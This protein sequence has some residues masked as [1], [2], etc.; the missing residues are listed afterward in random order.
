M[1]RESPNAA[2]SPHARRLAAIAIFASALLAVGFY[3]HAAGVGYPLDDS[4]IHIAFARHLAAGEGFG[5]NPGE[6][7][8]GATSP[9]WIVL[10][11]S[12]FLLGLPP[13]IW[14]WLLD[15][16]VL[17][18]AGLLCAR[19]VE[20]LSPTG[21]PA[22]IGTFPFAVACGVA[23]ASTGPLV[24]SAAGA[25]E[26]PLLA[27]LAAATFLA[28]AGRPPDGGWKTGLR[29]GVLAGLAG[30][31]RP[32]GL[33]ITPILALTALTR[34]GRKGARE[35]IAGIAAS[36]LVYSPSILFCLFT[37]GR[38]FP[39]TFYAKTTA[40][41]AGA[42][43]IGFLAG[44]ARFL[45]A[46][47]P[48]A[49]VALAVG[50][51]ALA[52]ALVRL[53]S[54]RSTRTALAIGA[55]TIGLPLAYASMGRTFLF[56]GLAGNFGRYLYPILPTAL[57]L[58][59]WG[60]SYLAGSF[61]LTKKILP[62]AF[63][64]P[65][66]LLLALSAAGTIR[67]ASL[68]RRNVEDV[69]SMQVAMANRLATRF[70]PGTYVAA[71]DVGAI[72]ALT[73]F[74]VLDLVGIISTPTLDALEKAGSARAARRQALIDLI[75]DERPDVLVVFPEWYEPL[76]ER[77]GDGL[78]EVENIYRPE[79]ITSGGAQLVAFRVHWNRV[80]TTGG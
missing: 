13:E 41:V 6:P 61:R 54:A 32:E 15:A 24:W 18:V 73:R 72:C 28:F 25:M 36:A 8:P 38:I 39:N 71:N 47:S 50:L 34:G 35:G 58:G 7:A 75:L 57:V 51:A 23:V 16:I 4:W 14:P 20:V 79:N 40:L 62:A 26:T 10:L 45:L 77:L 27:A 80:R 19:L 3:R 59:F 49:F 30:L 52:V 33:L 21:R 46:E 74:R 53:D 55:F 11:A 22:T 69:N 31:A 12:G 42:P 68:Y 2:A 76:L 9:L 64:F 63:A 48:A 29:W 60:A 17:G 5:A 1:K 56:A 70:A 78:E 44:T 66:L 65:L 43:D 37:S 67:R